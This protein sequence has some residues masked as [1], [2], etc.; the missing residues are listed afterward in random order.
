ME[1]HYLS[2]D[3]GQVHVRV[4]RPA[5]STRP[6]LVCLHP[7]PYS[8]LFFETI[9]PALAAHRTVMSPDYPGYGASDPGN[10]SIEAYAAAVRSAVLQLADESPVDVLGF[11]TGCL[12]GPQ[13]ALQWPKDLR[14]LVLCDIPLFE[15]EQRTALREQTAVPPTFTADLASIERAWDINVAQRLDRVPL[16]R[17]LALLAEQL[18]TGDRAHQGFGA[19]FD[20]DAEKHLA[21]LSHDTLVLATKSSLL[22]PSRAA[23]RLIPGARLEERLEVVAPAFETGVAELAEATLA[24]LDDDC[25]ANETPRSEA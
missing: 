7:I 1:R 5:R 20:W 2:T 3:Y 15:S 11:H 16:N 12:V 14:R 9:T 19:A 24:F 21:R 10:A 6:P 23:A 18:R 17:A 4:T 22:E 25:A 13:W 8:G